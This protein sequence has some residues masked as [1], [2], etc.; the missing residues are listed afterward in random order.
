MALHERI[1]A[2]PDFAGASTNMRDLLTRALLHFADT[3]LAR[4]FA[5]FHAAKLGAREAL[6]L[7]DLP[8]FARLRYVSW[9]H[10][11]RLANG[12]PIDPA[13]VCAQLERAARLVGRLHAVN[14]KNVQ[15]FR[16]KI[17]FRKRK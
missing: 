7:L 15:I 9:T 3:L 1:S 10:R 4:V 2:S 14:L 13:F 16:I 8:Q 5:A 11:A 6:D 12:A 17:D